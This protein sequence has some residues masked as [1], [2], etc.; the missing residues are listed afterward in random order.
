MDICKCI[1][2]LWQVG[3]LNSR[4]AASPLMRLVEEEERWEPPDHPQGVVPQNWGGTETDRVNLDYGKSHRNAWSETLS[5]HRY[6]D[7]KH[8]EIR[9]EKEEKTCLYYP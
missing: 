9:H 4:R 8:K 3:T 6:D 5:C 7:R 2:P 1:V